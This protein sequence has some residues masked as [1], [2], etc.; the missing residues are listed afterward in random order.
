MVYRHHVLSGTNASVF[1][2]LTWLFGYLGF[3]GV[4]VLPW[5]GY[6]E[7]EPPKSPA[8]AWTSSAAETQDRASFVGTQRCGHCHANELQLW[9]SSHH[10]WAMKPAAEDSVLGDFNDQLFE[11]QQVKTRFSRKDHHYWVTTLNEEG[12]MTT[13][14]IAFTF[15]VYPLQQYLVEFSGGRL[16]ALTIA[17]D[18]R[19]KEQGG[20][21]WFHLYPNRLISPGDALH[22]TSPAF[23]WNSQCAECHVTGFK[24]NFDPE[25]QSYASTWAESNVGCEGCHGPGSQHISWAEGCSDNNS[26]TCE[27]ESTLKGFS[28]VLKSATQWRLSRSQ[29]SSTTP[30]RTLIPQTLNSTTASVT[31][32][33]VCARCHSRRRAFNDIDFSNPSFFD[34]FELQLLEPPF[35]YSDGQ[36]RDEVYVF[37]SFIQSKMYHNGVTCSDCHN[38]HSLRLRAEGNALCAQCHNP[39]VFDQVGH[40]HHQIASTGAQCINCHMPETTYM[41]V[42]PRRD[43]SLRIPRPDL[44]KRTGVPNACIQCHLEQSNTWAHRTLSVWFQE[45]RNEGGVHYGDIFSEAASGD[46]TRVEELE[47]LAFDIDQPAMVRASAFSVLGQST[48]ISPSAIETMSPLVRIG[49]ARQLAPMMVSNRRVAEMRHD[50]VRGVRMAIA[51][52][53]MPQLAEILLKDDAVAYSLLEKEFEQSLEY[54]QDNSG[55][56]VALGIYYYQRGRWQDAERIYI[57]AIQQEPYLL[58]AYINLADIYR[59]TKREDKAEEILLKATK[60]DV[61]GIA[62]HSLGLSL[63]RQKQYVEAI[64]NLARAVAIAPK[65]VQFGYV[66]AVALHKTGQVDQA[67]A[68]LEALQLLRP[69][70]AFV[71]KALLSFYLQKGATE[72]ALAVASHL[73]ELEPSNDKWS[74]IKVQL[75]R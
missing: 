39:Q 42:D 62:Y 17:W 57:E 6:A 41:V 67:I 14:R 15:G 56:R 46:K 22:W 20:Q 40:H 45:S 18:T 34:Q 12:T 48:S 10:D 49:A 11:H 30:Y 5:P 55:G 65:N 43:H 7:S 21:K 51:R 73:A 37:G 16:Q 29:T 53:L 33:E 61:D 1:A 27:T 71:L 70:Q 58:S 4:L 2:R 23:T 24:K 28:Y 9:N 19:A 68:E 38:P 54:S 31:Q 75:G 52:S 35:Y 44:S 8:K 64:E 59:A 36:I 3:F 72:Q 25:I 50:S 60:Y 26:Q 13:Y 74:K 63:V 69:K 32:V 47:A 66:Y